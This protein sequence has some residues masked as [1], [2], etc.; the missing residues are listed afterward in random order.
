MVEENYI[1]DITLQV[2]LAGASGAGCSP[3]LLLNIAASLCHCPSGV[4]Q[5]LS[6]AHQMLLHLREPQQTKLEPRAE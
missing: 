1:P 3:L 2:L 6:W 4:T 5:V